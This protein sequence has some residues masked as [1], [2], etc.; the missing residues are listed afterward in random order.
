MSAPNRKGTGLGDALGIWLAIGAA[1]VIGGGSWVSAH[2]GSWMAGLASPPAHPIDL[3]AGLAKGRV[4][5]PVQSTIVACVLLGVLISLTVTVL[6]VRSRTAHKRTRVDKAAVHMG[7]GKDLDHL[8]TKGATATAVRLG[9]ENSTGVRLGRSV[10]GKRPL[11]ASWEDMLILIAGPRTMKTT[12]YAVPAILDAPGAVIATSNKRDIVDV[13]RPIRTEAGAVWVFDPQAVAEEEPTW[14]WN[15]LSYV[16]NEATAGNLAQ[17]FANG[18]REPGTKPDAY[19]DPA[20]Q[21]LLKAFLLAASLDS[22][23]VTQ[24]YTW[25]TRPHDD[26]PA[27]LLRTAGYDLLSDMV[28]GHIREPEK[29][30]AGVY[31]TARQMVSCLTDREVSQWVTPLRDTTVDTDPRPQFVPEDFVRGNGTLYSLSREGVGT[32]GPLVT[33][34]TVAVVEAAEKYATSQPGGRLAT[35]LLG[36]LDEA[37]NVCRWK[38]LPDQYSHYGSRGIILM[39]ILQSWSQGVEVWS[40]EGMRKLWSASN[41]KIYG[42]GVSEVGY[43]DEL[44]RL[45]GQYSYINV[46][47]SHSKTGSS[48]SRQENKDEILSV[49]DLTA[50]PRFRAILLTSG[51]PATMIETIPWMNG[52]HAQKVKDSLATEVNVDGEPVTVAAHNPWTDGDTA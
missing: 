14:W 52:P 4:P 45:I 27:E 18:S 10:A 50:L 34:L 28:I 13:T 49:A 3:V 6:V 24:V 32:A 29:Q 35:P 1:V 44:S 31:G 22:A 12:S 16:K 26:A 46:S 48:S 42:G 17:H 8:G 9:V 40:L 11:W 37:A 41:V 43:L 36:I 7:R 51:A 21:N 15:P 19:F 23:P 33:A 2:L 47:R 38:A 30:R 39:T 5:W 20:G 25:L